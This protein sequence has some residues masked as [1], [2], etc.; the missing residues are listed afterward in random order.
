[1]TRD[2]TRVCAS[3]RQ[4]KPEPEFQL[5]AKRW[6]ASC[7]ACRLALRQQIAAALAAVPSPAA[8]PAAPTPAPKPRRKRLASAPAAPAP[9]PTPTPA[10]QPAPAPVG[11]RLRPSLSDRPGAMDAFSLPSM[12]LG[13]RIWR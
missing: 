1:M 13:K 2:S 12:E 8:A 10:P 3:C 7:D 5:G 9:Q 4:P 6:T 11:P